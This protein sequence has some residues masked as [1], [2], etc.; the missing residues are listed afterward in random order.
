MSSRLDDSIEAASEI[1]MR[2]HAA[3]GAM[4]VGESKG[5]LPPD[6][7]V[8]DERSIL[9]DMQRLAQTYHDPSECSMC[10]DRIGTMFALLGEP[11]FDARQCC[12]GAAA[13]RVTAHPSCRE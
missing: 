6:S 8:E 9:K 2:F 10:R 3:R 12:S 4:S 13:W 7:V 1:G 5:G 11:R